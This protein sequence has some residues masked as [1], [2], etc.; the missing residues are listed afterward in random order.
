MYRKT[1]YQVRTRNNLSETVLVMTELK[2]GDI[3]LTLLFKIELEK[4]VR[5]MQESSAVRLD[6][7]PINIKI[8]GFADDLIIIDK[9]IESVIRST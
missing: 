6:V 3:L 2:Q 1:K 5:I 8:L 9:N 7:D 4:V